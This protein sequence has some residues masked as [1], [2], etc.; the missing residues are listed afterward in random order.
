MQNITPILKSLGL[1][2][3]EVKVYLAAL[4]LGASTV[5]EI[6]KSTRLSRPATYTAIGTLGERG[7]MSTVQQGKRKLFAA[8]HPDRLLHYAKRKEQELHEQ[9]A[10]LGRSLPE[11]ALRVGG[12]KPVV[13]SFVGKEGLHAIAEDYSAVRPREILEMTNIDAMLAVLTRD[14]LA[15]MR[16]ALKH[17]G[18]RVR[19]LYHG[20]HVQQSSLPQ[21]PTRILPEQ[22]ASFRGHVGIYGDHVALATFTGKLHS[23]IIEN[24]E[25]ANT[26]R[27]LFEMAW[28]HAAELPE[29]R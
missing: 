9:V 24:A 17:M 10:D 14:D 2:E 12:E 22:Y 21:S 6:A 20:A 3:S 23:V 8:E 11:L 18:T 5:I 25:V 29:P 15:P 19:G 4:E 26:I 16:N 7:L 28:M 13:K 1:L 27:A